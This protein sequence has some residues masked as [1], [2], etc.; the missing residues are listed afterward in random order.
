[1]M[2]FMLSKK[3]MDSGTLLTKKGGGWSRLSLKS[4]VFQQPVF[5]LKDGRKVGLNPGFMREQWEVS[6]NK[7]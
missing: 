7:N 6:C 5:I 3:S 2:L 4:N 1:M